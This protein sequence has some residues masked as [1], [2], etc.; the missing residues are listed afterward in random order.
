VR[1][2]E[3]LLR[4]PPHELR[5]LLASRDPKMTWLRLSSPFVTA[6]GIDF[7]E[8]RARRRIRRA[9]K[10]VAARASRTVMQGQRA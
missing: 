10:R 7:T 4:Y 1:D 5:V 9:A 3:E 2:W 8:P 6:E